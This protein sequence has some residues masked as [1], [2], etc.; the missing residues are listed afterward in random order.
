MENGAKRKG[1]TVKKGKKQKKK[2][3]KK[4]SPFISCSAFVIKLDEK[5][6]IAVTPF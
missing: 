5:Y 4:P 6:L 1:E 2:K 3:T